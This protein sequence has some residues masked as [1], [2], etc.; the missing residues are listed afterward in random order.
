MLDVGSLA[1]DLSSVSLGQMD[2]PETVDQTGVI[3]SPLPEHYWIPSADTQRTLNLRVVPEKRL[4]YT[5]PGLSTDA[6]LVKL[7]STLS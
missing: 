2:Q 3:D 1:R 6:P 5:M 4:C 7:S